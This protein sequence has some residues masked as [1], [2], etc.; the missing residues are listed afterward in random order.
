MRLLIALIMVFSVSG[1]ALTKHL[2]KKKKPVPEFPGLDEY[3]FERSVDKV[4]ELKSANVQTINMRFDGLSLKE[5]MTLL[6]DQTG[7]SIV[8]AQG[9]DEMKLYGSYFGEPLPTV[10]ESVARRVNASLSE[11]NGIYFLGES[12]SNEVVTAVVRNLPI[13][14]KELLD[15]LQKGV[16]D[17]GKVSVVGGSLYVSDNLEN[18]R[19]LLVDIEMLR[20][21]AEHSYIAEVFFIRV[22]EDD[23]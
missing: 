14:N 11:V 6:T 12:F 9:L 10:L 1:C 15:A 5:A 19:K 13:E 17:H 18:V 2:P 7:V 8:W 3:S 4:V 22:K 16:S 23:F 20:E 21:Q